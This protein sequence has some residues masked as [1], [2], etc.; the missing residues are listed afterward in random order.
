MKEVVRINNSES[1]RA[2][3]N[4]YIKNTGRKQI[5]VLSK[6]ISYFLSLSPAEREAFLNSNSGGTPQ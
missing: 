1:E 6:L 4:D 3:L 2:E 5:F